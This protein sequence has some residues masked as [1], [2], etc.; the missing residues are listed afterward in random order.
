MHDRELADSLPETLKPLLKLARNLWWSWNNNS[1]LLFRDI[2][3]ERWEAGE[4]NP[5]SLLRS[6]PHERLSQLA[7][8]PDFLQRLDHTV[9]QFDAYMGIAPA[10]SASAGGASA[11]PGSL[12]PKAKSERPIAY[13]CAEYGI[14]ESL[15]LYAG[16]L[17]MLAG[18]HLKSASD[19]GL[20]L[21][22]IGLLYRQGYFQQR[23][24]VDGWQ[25][26]FY[27]DADFDELPFSLLRNAEGSRR[28]TYRRVTRR[29]TCRSGA[30]VGRIPLFCSTPTATTTRR[31]IA[32]SP[33]T[34]TG[35]R[36]NAHRAGARARH[37]RGARPA[38]ARHHAA[39]LSPERGPLGLPHARA[40][41]RARR[42]AGAFDE[43]CKAVARSASSRPTRR[44]R[45]VT[46]SSTCAHAGRARALLE[47]ARHGRRNGA[48]A[49]PPPSDRHSRAL[50]HDPAR[51][52]PVA[53]DERRQQAPRRRLRP[54]VAAALA[55]PSGRGVAD[56]R[57]HQ[58]RAPPDLGCAADAALFEKYLG[59]DWALRSTTPSCGRG[60]TRSPT[61][62][63]GART[64][65]CAHDWSPWRGFAPTHSGAAGPGSTIS[66]RR[67]EA[68]P[69]RCPDLR[70]R[71]TRRGLQALE[72]VAPRH[73]AHHRD[74]RSSDAAGAVRPRR[75]GAS[76]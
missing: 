21:V 47:G 65:C 70:L 2:D 4:H 66:P 71:A 57:R 68:A 12:F 67:A 16:G 48:R 8:S 33:P 39:L 3:Y 14:H 40:G 41:A 17:G 56:R 32:G 29:C 19:L 73:A 11:K 50:R 64:A 6:V 20:P 61:R 75:Q 1:F 60:S 5:L 63:S 25:E 15:R 55:R 34:S 46:T 54:Y 26:E 24:N 76:A 31:S 59:E 38:R 36:R 53:L 35:A 51:D 49:R 13:F 27:S 37:R 30:P 45:R 22:A 23:V 18:D 62:S 52:P 28:S 9:R 74:A 7:V 42:A 43:A 10:E 72:S 69:S 58:R 44:C